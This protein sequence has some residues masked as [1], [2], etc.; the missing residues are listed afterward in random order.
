MKLLVTKYGNEPS[1]KC[2]NEICRKIGA[3]IEM[4]SIANYQKTESFFSVSRNGRVAFSIDCDLIFQWE[5]ASLTFHCDASQIRNNKKT[6]NVFC[7]Y[8]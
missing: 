7:R 8:N 5:K 3:P 2:L 1:V 6:L 4:F